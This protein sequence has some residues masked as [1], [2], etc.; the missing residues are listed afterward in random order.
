MV[1]VVLENRN[2]VTQEI[3]ATENNLMYLLQGYLVGPW[4]QCGGS[5]A[6]A[7]CHAVIE[8]GW[9]YL[10]CADDDELG[11]LELEPNS[12]DRS[13]LCCQISLDTL[14]SD[15]ILKIKVPHSD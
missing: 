3:E 14:P 8:Q 5:C 4:G 7:T 13:R 10:A 11:L 1:T 6:C 15:A 12:T 2:G 9:E